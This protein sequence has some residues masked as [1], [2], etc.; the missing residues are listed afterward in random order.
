MDIENNDIKNK[1]YTTTSIQARQF[2]VRNLMIHLNNLASLKKDFKILLFLA[3]SFQKQL[4]RGYGYR[5]FET[6]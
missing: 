3:L 2:E 1:N 5:R 6:S 4:R